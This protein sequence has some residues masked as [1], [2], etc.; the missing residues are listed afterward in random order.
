MFTQVWKKYFPVI[1]IL[2]KRS[3]QQ[4]QSL[5]MNQTDFERAAG[6]RKARLSF[7][8]IKIINGRVAA[9]SSHPP[10]AKEFALLMQQEE[11][12][13]SLLK[14][15]QLEFSLTGNFELLIRDCSEPEVKEEG[16]APGTIPA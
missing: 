1:A 11:G 12:F 4:E 7:S 15:R 5:Q 2:I 9:H 16:E 6:G 14:E 8:R 3:A 13:S 10:L